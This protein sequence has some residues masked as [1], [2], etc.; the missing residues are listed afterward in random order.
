MSHLEFTAVYG[1]NLSLTDTTYTRQLESQIFELNKSSQTL[2]DLIQNV[3]DAIAVLDHELHIKILNPSFIHLFSDVFSIKIQIGM[4]I[5]TILSDFPESKNKMISACHN[6]LFDKPSS[7]LLENT[8]LAHQAYYCY[9][10]I[11]RTIY[12]SHATQKKFILHLRDL[13]HI[14]LNKKIEHQRLA[15]LALAS[16]TSAMGEMASAFAHEITQ[17]LAAINAYTQSCL[18]ILKNN[19]QDQQTNHPL[20]FPLEQISRQA[21]NAGDIIHNMNNFIRGEPVM[22]EETDLNLL[23]QETLP[24]LYYETLDFKLKISLDLMEDLPK[25]MCNKIHLMQILLNLGKN[26]IESLKSSPQ[27]HNEIII[28]TRALKHTIFVRV[29]DNGPGIHH[30]LK[31]LGLASYFSTKPQGSGIGLGI[32]RS[33]IE[34]HRGTLSVQKQRAHGARFTFTLP[35][36]REPIV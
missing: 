26:S 23:I 34:A 28:K 12:Y 29:M 6:A 3:S 10:I 35:I 5:G 27:E 31:H 20:L 36:K 30:Q 15:G 17:P 9:E 33:L 1:H 25:V 13:T 14:Q 32:C 24:I 16:R 7:V 18:F 11:A 8:D 4:N 19:L 22:M 2:N 21:E